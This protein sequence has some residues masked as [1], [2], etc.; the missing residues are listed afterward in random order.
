MIAQF[1]VTIVVALLVFAAKSSPIPCT[2]VEGSPYPCPTSGLNAAKTL[3]GF[4]SYKLS[5]TQTW[6]LQSLQGVLSRDMPALI[7]I[8]DTGKDLWASQLT[9]QYGVTIDDSL[10]E[11]FQNILKLFSKDISGYVLSS[12]GQS[13][14]SD[15]RSGAMTYVAANSTKLIVVNVADEAVAQSVGIQKVADAPL[16]SDLYSFISSNPSLSSRIVLLQDPNKYNAGLTDYS[17]FANAAIWWDG[18]G[19]TSATSTLILGS[20]S[21]AQASDPATAA[22][23]GWGDG[24]EAQN[25]MK[26]SKN[27]GFIHASDYAQ[28]L[29]TLTGFGSAI[30][31]KQK[32]DATTSLDAKK[33]T[34]SF[35]F[36]DGDNVQW[37]LNSMTTDARW[38]G[39]PNRGKVP[40]C[41]DPYNTLTTLLHH[42]LSIAKSAL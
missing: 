42:S 21:S 28:N 13:G 25:V 14:A 20:L 15:D 11:D 32:R 27:G 35:L 40:V 38:F 4:N 34:I 33:H 18:E 30:P 7:E 37:M 10:A 19:L 26:I 39:S 36:S 41:F 16:N 2:R 5:P 8:G 3:Y 17:S 24:D 12:Y 31:P 23:L 6:T 1:I 29:A 22:V 9:S